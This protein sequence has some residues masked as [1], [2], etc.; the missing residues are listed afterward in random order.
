MGPIHEKLLLATAPRLGYAY[1]RLVRATM[2]A[3]FR[4]RE[5]LEERSRRGERYILA[6]WHSRLVMMPY[7]YPGRKITVLISRHR[8]AEIIGRVLGRFG[9]DLS[10]GSSSGGGAPAL[11][12]ILRKVADGYDVAF[13]PDGP[14]GP[15]RRAK[16]GVVAAARLTGLP[17]I[18]VA[19][20]AAPAARVDSWDRT[21]V[22]RPFCRGVY[23]CGEPIECLRRSDPDSDEESRQRIESELDRLTDAADREAGLALE[24]A[25]PPEVPR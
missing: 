11:R 24:P 10:R 13:T 17:V 9:F 19:Y 12:D 6:F 23:V 15:R 3:S 5:I 18:P 2:R 21:L 4:G 22:P 1:I 14:R 16:G 20:S 25:R 7:V 8:D